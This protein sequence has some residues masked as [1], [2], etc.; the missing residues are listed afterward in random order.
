MFSSHLFRAPLGVPFFLSICLSLFS[1]A[2]NADGG[3]LKRAIEGSDF[4]SAREALFEVIEAEGLVVGQ[5]LPFAQMLE[6]TGAGTNYRQAEIVQFCSA[7]LAHQMVNEDLGQIVFCPLAISLYVTVANPAVVVLAYRSPGKDTAARRQA[8][9]LLERLVGRAE[10][11]AK[12][13]W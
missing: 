5:V 12:L 2:A 6:R 9:E 7:G 10:K 11:L 3:V 8:G 13:R 4:D 1:L